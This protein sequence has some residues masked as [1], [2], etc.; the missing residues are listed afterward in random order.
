MILEYEKKQSIYAE[1]VCEHIV[2]GVIR[3]D[4]LIRT[5]YIPTN[6]SAEP[7]NFLLRDGHIDW[8]K[9]HMDFEMKIHKEWLE[10]LG[11]D[12]N[13]FSVDFETHEIINLE[14]QKEKD[15]IKKNNSFDQNISSKES[16]TL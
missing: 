8:D 10:E 16:S 11:Y 14:R 4:D 5:D 2:N 7:K 1:K 3:F 13:K 6:F 9:V 15:L 12:T